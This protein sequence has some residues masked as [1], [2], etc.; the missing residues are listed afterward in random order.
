MEQGRTSYFESPDLPKKATLLHDYPV[1]EQLQNIKLNTQRNW[2]PKNPIQIRRHIQNCYENSKQLAE[3][4]EQQ[5]QTLLDHKMNP[6]NYGKVIN[7]LTVYLSFSEATHHKIGNY[8]TFTQTNY[9]IAPEELK[10]KKTDCNA[11]LRKMYSQKEIKENNYYLRN[12]FEIS[13]FRTKT[14]KQTRI[15]I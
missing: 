14:G 11:V 4:I 2:I 13:P 8:T 7:R 6:E 12:R 10:L 1:N 15:S 9:V 3:D 5:L